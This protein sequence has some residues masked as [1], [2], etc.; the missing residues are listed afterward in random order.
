MKKNTD[1]ESLRSRVKSTKEIFT[2]KFVYF[3]NPG[4]RLRVIFPSWVPT[5]MDNH[6]F[7]LGFE[8]PNTI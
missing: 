5:L 6:L 2:Y 8:S 4:C 1:L 7:F 3:N